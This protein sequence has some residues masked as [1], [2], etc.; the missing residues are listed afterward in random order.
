MEQIFKIAENYF[1]YMA[2]NY[3]VMCASD[4]FYCLPCIEKTVEFPDSL[5]SF[6]KN[7]IKQHISHVKSLKDSLE[8]TASG[9]NNL[10]D[11]IDTV[12]LKESMVSFLREFEET[13]IWEIDPTLYLRIV[14]LGASNGS[15][16]R[17]NKIPQLLNEAK[18][19]LKGVRPGHM[20]ASKEMIGAS[21][22]YFKTISVK[23]AEAIEDFGKFLNS[24]NIRRHLIKDRV[25]LENILN[26]SF[27]YSLGL[28]EIFDIATEEYRITLIALKKLAKTIDPRKTWQKILSKYK[29]ESDKEDNVLALYESEIGKLKNFFKEK[30]IISI[31]RMQ[32][33]LVEPTPLFMKP[34]RASASYS[35]PVTNK[36]SESA[37]FYVTVDF[38]KMEIHNEYKFVTAHETYPGH[39]LLDSVRRSLKNPIRR[40]IESP[41]FYEGWASYAEKLIDELGYV[42]SPV[43]KLPGLRRQAWRAV[44]AMLD[45]GLRI[46]RLDLEDAS[47]MLRD[48]GYAAG[49]VKLMLRHYALT[50][51]YQLCYTMGKFEI[52]NL[53]K[54][55]AVKMGLKKFHDTLI[56]AGEIPFYLIEKRME[57]KV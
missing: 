6:D 46:G 3:P 30:D 8:K 16:G 14:L 24:V 32:N 1:D 15:P 25:T 20:E 53:R 12:L 40:Q 48:L 51:G 18:S 55:F 52:E 49:T 45:V 9:I 43:H 5:D 33:I 54:K 42:K 7:R 2:R 10:E 19:N 39:H 29:I 27:S 38:G 36:L 57:G 23:A 50:P 41:L 13:K 31:S 17:I 56:E 26:G 28:D 47:K 4:E 37:R 44:R 21:I 11:E 22:D 35:A 34:V